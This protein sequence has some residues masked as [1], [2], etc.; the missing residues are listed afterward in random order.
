MSEVKLVKLFAEANRLAQWIGHKNWT[1]R[2][3]VSLKNNLLIYHKH[4]SQMSV[5]YLF[6]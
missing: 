6:Y 2:E 3:L 5:Y 4:A 1:K